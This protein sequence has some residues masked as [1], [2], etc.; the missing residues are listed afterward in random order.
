VRFQKVYD[1]YTGGM[2]TSTSSSHESCQA[3]NPGEAKL[4]SGRGV[5]WREIEREREF[6]TG[7]VW[8]LASTR[9]KRERER[10]RERERQTYRR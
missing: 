8:A 7:I 4:E 9:S 5:R 10:E 3:S 2:G 6:G 1:V